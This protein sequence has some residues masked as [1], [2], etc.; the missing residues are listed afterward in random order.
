MADPAQ[1]VLVHLIRSLRTAFD[2]QAA[3]PPVGGGTANVRFFAGDSI[4]LAAW[5]AH[6][7]GCGCNEPFLWVRLVQRYRTKNFPEPFRG[8]ARCNETSSALEIEVGAARCAIVK[9]EPEWCDWEKEAA[10]NLDDSRRVDAALCHAMAC[11]RDADDVGLTAI[12]PVV[13]WGPNGGVIA[14][15]GTVWVQV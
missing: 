7:E 2:P 8:A 10:V 3:N 14:V 4:P 11:A 6:A 5:D 12:G 9:E 1:D 15:Y 13:P